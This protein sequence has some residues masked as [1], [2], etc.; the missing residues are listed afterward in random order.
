MYRIILFLLVI[1]TGAHAKDP[2]KRN[3]AIDVQ[4]YIFR[5]EMNDS[6][7]MIDGK[8]T[9]NI[10]FK[11]AVNEFELDLINKNNAVCFL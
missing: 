7:D 11:S 5:L 2:Y 9:V 4:H 1:S 3:A 8:A 6:T 10:L